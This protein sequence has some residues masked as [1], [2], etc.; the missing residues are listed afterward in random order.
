MREL[1][2]VKAGADE[3]MVVKKRGRQRCLCT[4][5]LC[6]K[7]TPRLRLCALTFDTAYTANEARANGRNR[8]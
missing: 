7:R 2:I 8:V 3:I 4:L 1:W 5:P 6:C